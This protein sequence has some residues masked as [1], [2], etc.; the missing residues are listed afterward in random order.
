MN[1]IYLKI[2]IFIYLKMNTNTNK[3]NLWQSHEFNDFIDIINNEIIDLP[4]SLKI[5]TMCCGCKLNTNLLIKNIE[6]YFQLDSKDILSIKINDESL[7]TLLDI[8]KKPKR[9][10]KNKIKKNNAS[11]K[12]F[13]NQV[14]VVIRINDNETENIN[15]ESKINLKLFKNGSVQ[16]SG[17]KSIKDVNRVLNKLIIKLKEI[18][19]IILN[20]E[21]IDKPFIESIDNINIS[22]FKIDMI[23]VHYKINMNINRIKLYQLLLK[24]KLKVMYEPCIRACVT[25]KYIPLIDNID[26][27][28]ISI[29][30]FEKG[31]IIITSARSRNQIIETYDYINNILITYKND[32][33]KNEHDIINIYNELL[34]NNIMSKNKTLINQTSLINDFKSLKI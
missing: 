4:P 32:I 13:Y 12:F 29:F 8:K 23:L 19:A 16:M 20:N 34:N 3:N 1:K 24:K 26:K 11:N 15:N 22:H 28:E 25:L 7:R 27:K 18:K 33:I 17:C 2:L 31:N 14:T 9:I 5:S 6:N 10:K 21:I 30:F